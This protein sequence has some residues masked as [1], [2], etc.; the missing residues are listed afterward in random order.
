M[1]RKVDYV[2]S[3]PDDCVRIKQYNG[4]KYENLFY[5]PSEDSFYQAPALRFR[6]LSMSDGT[7]RPISDDGAISRI[8]VSTFKKRTSGDRLDKDIIM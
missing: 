5:S 6:K 7:V 1:S 2:D 3:I 4:K 8:T